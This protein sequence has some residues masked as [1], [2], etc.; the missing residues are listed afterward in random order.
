MTSPSDRPGSGVALLDAM[1]A[2]LIPEAH[3]AH[4]LAWLEEE[5]P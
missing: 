1:A 4:L 3:E 5:L 2:V